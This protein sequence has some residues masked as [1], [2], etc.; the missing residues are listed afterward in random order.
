MGI[1]EHKIQLL[2]FQK[3]IE[4]NHPDDFVDMPGLFWQCPDA[5]D[6]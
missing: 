3:A 1:E 5:F 6:I 2:S 4:D